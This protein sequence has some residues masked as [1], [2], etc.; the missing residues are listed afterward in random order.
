MSNDTLL[1]EVISKASRVE[2]IVPVCVA[3]HL[4][5]EHQQVSAE[6]Q[7]AA[8]SPGRMGDTTQSRLRERLV[9]IEKEM[10]KYT[11]EFRFRAMSAKEWSDLLV[12]HPDPDGQRAFNVDTFPTA[13]ISA[14]A[15]EPEGMD[16]P[17]KV[18]QLMD[19]LSPA[20]QGDLFDG[21]WEVNTD[22]PKG[23]SWLTESDDHQASVTSL[24]SVTSTESPEA[25]S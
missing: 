19:I 22:S 8:L 25:T 4:V 7:D 2:R 1:D 11:Y 13:A 23:Q 16:N 24:R 9:D 6:L 18:Q 15:I 12:A 10:K 5:A 21:A 3:G 20:Q 14:C 17:E